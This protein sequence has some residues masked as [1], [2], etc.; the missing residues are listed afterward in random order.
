MDQIKCF[1]RLKEDEALKRNNDKL[2]QR[3]RELVHELE[4]RDGL[5]QQLVNSICTNHFRFL[6]FIGKLSFYCGSSTSTVSSKLKASEC[7]P[8]N[9]SQSVFVLRFYSFKVSYQLVCHVSL[10]CLNSRSNILF[11]INVKHLFMNE[12]HEIE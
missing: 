4:K 10:L 7:I 9:V 3:Y 2:D 5:W 12:F 8:P 11:F 6:F 1:M